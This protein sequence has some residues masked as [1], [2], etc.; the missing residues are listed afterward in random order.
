VGALTDEPEHESKP[1]GPSVLSYQN[2]VGTTIGGQYRVE[3]VLGVGGMGYVVAAHDTALDRR[4]AI[5]LIHRDRDRDMVA[6]RR[7]RREGRLTANLDHPNIVRVHAAGEDE[8]LGLYL[9][10]ERLEGHTLRDHIV[11]VR[12]YNPGTLIKFLFG[13]LEG[14]AAAHRAGVVH[15][16]LKPENV[17]V[18]ERGEDVVKLLDFG[19]A[20]YFQPLINHT[21]V[22]GKTPPLGTSDYMSP[23]QM[24]GNDNL[25]ARSDVF[26]VGVILYE[27]FAFGPPWIVTT[28]PA[29]VSAVLYEPLPDIRK[30]SPWPVSES[31]ARVI[32]RALERD[33][34]K[35]FANAGELLAAFREADL[36]EIRCAFLSERREV[37]WEQ[38]ARFAQHLRAFRDREQAAWDALG[39]QGQRESHG[40]HW[41]AVSR[42]MNFPD[43]VRTLVR[44]LVE[45]GASTV[46]PKYPEPLFVMVRNAPAEFEAE[47]VAAGFFRSDEEL[48][49]W[50][51]DPSELERH[52]KDRPAEVPRFKR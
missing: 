32:E 31:L 21:T 11:M 4:V 24:L 2:L 15:R 51:A 49:R 35:R 16:D 9:V 45:A 46:R 1:T 48:W 26:S 42:D 12:T 47:L 52:V 29:L 34:D 25:D 27:V 22:T 19:L 39:V 3:S 8:T 30:R 14:L 50:S 20:K 23:E 40:R 7:F 36:S 44:R 33:R 43:T 10:Q 37:S 38:T 28:W 41:W 5:K 13:M 6:G 17:F 18:D